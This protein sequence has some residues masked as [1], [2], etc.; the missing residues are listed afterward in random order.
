MTITQLPGIDL[1]LGIPTAVVTVIRTLPLAGPVAAGQLQETGAALLRAVPT[2]QFA[3]QGETAGPDEEIS[4]GL[5]EPL[6]PY[7][8]LDGVYIGPGP[9]WPRTSR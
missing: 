4:A 7:T 3:S 5:Q 8:G 1:A 6:R 9:S 2:R